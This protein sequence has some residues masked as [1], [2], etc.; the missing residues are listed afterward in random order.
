MTKDALDLLI[1]DHREVEEVFVRLEAGGTGPEERKELVEQVTIE[2]IRHAVAEEQYLY[3]FAK[4]HLPEGDALQQQELGDHA[5]VEVLLKRLEGMSA[6]NLDF[7]A[8]LRELMDEVRAHV[9][10]EEGTL[11]PQL[12]RAASAERLQRLGDRIETAKT[13]APTRPH[14]LA[15]DTPPLNK[16]LGPG[17]GLV[18]RV[19]DALTGRGAKRE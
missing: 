10:E 3:P 19:R 15:P 6:D 1:E 16:L 4:D 2:L 13:V 5:R 17:T 9:A 8:T 12:R 11:F 7:E 14:P 18:D